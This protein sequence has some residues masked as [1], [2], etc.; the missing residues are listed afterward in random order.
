[1]R[2]QRLVGAVEAAQFR[3]VV[4][5]CLLAGEQLGVAGQAGVHRVAAAMD[6]ARVRQD[7]PDQPGIEEVGRHLVHHM[8]A[9]LRQRL[10]PGKIGRRPSPCHLRPQSAPGTRTG[11]VPRLSTTACICRNSPAPWISG[12][13]ARI[14]STSVVPERGMPSTNTGTG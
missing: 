9:A 4:A 1:M 11:E 10:D 14:C 5:E 7:Q 6:D 13:D 12:C 2:H 8:P 3:L